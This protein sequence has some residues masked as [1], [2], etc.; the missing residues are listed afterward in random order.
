LINTIETPEL[1]PHQKDFIKLF[2]TCEPDSIITV[3]AKRQVGK[4]AVAELLAL[5]Q[6]V[7][8]SNQIVIILEPTYKQCGRV[9]R[10]ILTLVKGIPVV[11]STNSMELTITFYNGSQIMFMSAATND[12]LRGPHVTSQAF[13]LID[14]AAYCKDEVAYSLL[15]VT[16]ACHAKTILISSP[17]FKN[18]IFYDFFCKGVQKEKHFYSLDWSKYDTSMLLSP[19]KL[20]QYRKAL[21]YPI[22][23][24][25]YLGEFLDG[26]SELWGDLTKVCTL[27][28]NNPNGNCDTIGI[29][30]SSGTNNDYTVLSGFNLFNE[31]VLLDYFNDKTPTDTIAYIVT[32]LKKYRPKRVVVEGNSIGEIYAD[33]LKKA[34]LNAGI[35]LK[36]EVF[37]MTNDSKRRIIETLIP[38]VHNQEVSF[39]NDTVLKLQFSGF[40]LKST[41]TGKITY[42]NE[43]PGIH[44]DIV[45]ATAICLDYLNKQTNYMFGTAR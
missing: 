38:K 37:Y 5:R 29:D 25:E 27:S 13:L 36:F 42:E 17:K 43:D 45:I 41:P 40:T 23:L 8:F 15:P 28:G 2:D 16:D 22:F 44:D 1:F 11:S 39:I 31:Q 24:C 21:P 14:E 6:C 26:V 7:N 18:G 34:I 35:N 19:D 32:Q 20:E 3:K 4:T 30:W 10:E 9:Y 33:M 12:T